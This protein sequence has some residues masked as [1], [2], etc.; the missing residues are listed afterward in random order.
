MTFKTPYVPH[1]F[2]EKVKS[3]L[4]SKSG[5]LTAGV[6]AS[7]PWPSYDVCIEYAGDEYFLRGTEY[8]KNRHHV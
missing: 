3:R 7:I 1:L 4:K 2:G 8:E 5:W 6:A